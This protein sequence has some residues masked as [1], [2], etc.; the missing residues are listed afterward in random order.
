[1]FILDGIRKKA[2][3]IANVFAGFSAHAS[4]CKVKNM[5]TLTVDRCV[6]DL[7][8]TS[9]LDLKFVAVRCPNCNANLFSVT[10][11]RDTFSI[12]IKCRRCTS[13][14]R[15][16]VYLIVEISLEPAQ[17]SFIGSNPENSASA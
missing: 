5:N 13:K 10:P 17:R 3:E 1:M 11:T 7:M 2:R 12:R 4:F 14:R 9:Q 15:V 8:N 6:K 16:P